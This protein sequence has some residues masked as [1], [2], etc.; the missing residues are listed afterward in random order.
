VKR[1]ALVLAVSA[2]LS[3]GCAQHGDN[4]VRL[5][6]FQFKPEAIE[7]FDRI[8]A[9]FEREH[10]GIDVQQN[11]TPTAE[12][13]IRARL[14]KEDVPDVIALNGNGVFG[15]LASAGV[16]H[17]FSGTP[18]V[19][20][21]SPPI[22]RILNDLGVHREG[23]VN[24]L[25]FASNANG[26]IYN[27]DLFREHGVEPPRTWSELT[28][29]AATFREAGVDPFYMTPAD[30]WT[31]LPAFNALAANLPPPDFFDR[32]EAGR[33]TFA[34]EYGP[35]VDK[36]G[37]L[38]RQG[39][40][41]RFS[42]GYDD[43]NQAFAQGKAAMYLQGSYAI[44][45]IKQFEPGFEI[46]VFALPATDDAQATRLVSGVDVALTLGREPEHP[47]EA[48]AFLAY[49]MRPEV[50]ESYAREQLAIPP[51]EGGASQD[52]ALDGVMPY[53][54]EGRLIGYADH[55]I[56]LTIPL[57]QYLQQ[58]V[59][60]GNRDAFLRRLDVEWDKVAARRS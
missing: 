42:R 39:Q 56:P 29:A 47:E 50:M 31:T 21:V 5:E 58:Y 13:A 41:D 27:K 22:Q 36:L 59:I 2:L 7:T 10:P 55:R 11:H 16:F 53:F 30:A 24:G 28:Q 3:A 23:E 44:P 25:P 52:P 49:L 33:V 20:G 4:R 48:M 9:D 17:D 37:E 1:T 51:I 18:L 46:G 60:D 38:F 12:S 19:R 6:F 32:R 45:A 54:E 14:V 26:V 8:I 43:G 35:V 34:Q 57:E 15:E 40:R